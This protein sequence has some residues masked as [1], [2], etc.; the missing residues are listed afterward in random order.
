MAKGYGNVSERMRKYFKHLEKKRSAP[1]VAAQSRKGGPHQE[2]SR[3]PDIFDDINEYEE[4]E[5]EELQER[6]AP[7][8]FFDVGARVRVVAGDK[9][10]GNDGRVVIR[11]TVDGS[12]QYGV[13]F[14][15]DQSMIPVYFCGKEL[16]KCEE[17]IEFQLKWSRQ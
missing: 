12:L 5:M 13:V 16:E 10:L 4:E 17:E 6:Q 9:F 3:R 1:A 14:D 2:G 8:P 11:K 15:W 7:P